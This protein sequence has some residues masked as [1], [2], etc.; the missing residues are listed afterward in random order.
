MADNEQDSDIE[1]STKGEPTKDDP[2]APKLV[3]IKKG[4]R[5]F[6]FNVRGQVSEGGQMRAINGCLYPPLQM[7]SA[8]LEGGPAYKAGVRVGDRI[9]EV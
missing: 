1:T 5:G 2:Y 9:L 3:R 8:V 4:E 7:I 6:G